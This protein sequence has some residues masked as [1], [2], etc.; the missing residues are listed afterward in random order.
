MHMH[1][2]Q[3]AAA[4]SK[5]GMLLTLANST[6]EVREVQRLRYRVFVEGGGLTALVN[7]ERLDADRFDKHCDHLIVR[8]ANTLRV[9]G[10][11]A[12]FRRMLRARRAAT[13]R[14]ASSISRASGICAMGLWKRGAHA[15]IRSTAA[16]PS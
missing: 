5:T 13:T 1:L 10:T 4:V 3:D 9:V 14:R 16:V 7:R 15:S 12:C 6:E 2:A 8:D 11:T